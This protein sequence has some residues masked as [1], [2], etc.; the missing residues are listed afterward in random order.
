MNTLKR[1]TFLTAVTLAIG[2][3]LVIANAEIVKANTNVSTET[4]VSGDASNDPSV[5][6]SAKTTTVTTTTNPETGEV[7]Q[8]TFV[9]Y[10][11][12]GDGVMDDSEFEKYSYN[13]IDYDHDGKISNDEWN[14]YNSV[15]FKPYTENVVESKT[16]IGYDKDGNGF[17]E[18]SEY[19]AAYEPTIYTYWDVDG[20]G[21]V[22][23]VEYKNATNSYVTYDTKHYYVW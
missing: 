10:D 22:D 20:D 3:G 14:Y 2:G 12:N 6:G 11:K 13:M 5:T 7:T 18:P 1:T 23:M 8:T 4:S 9:E 15:W 19:E 17:I 21:M 16:F